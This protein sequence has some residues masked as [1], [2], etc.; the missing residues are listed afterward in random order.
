MLHQPCLAPQWWN[1]K[2]ELNLKSIGLGIGLGM[3]RGTPLAD[4]VLMTNRVYRVK[5]LTKACFL[6]EISPVEAVPQMAVLTNR[7][8]ES[9][10][11]RL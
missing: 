3:R 7:Q 5:R 4:S 8:R 9:R 11:Q 10:S 2:I 6:N 1:S